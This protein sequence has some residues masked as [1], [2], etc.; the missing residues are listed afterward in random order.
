MLDY[1]PNNLS[2]LI[3]SDKAVRIIGK[4][5][6]EAE[7]FLVS[8]SSEKS[9][10]T[11]HANVVNILTSVSAMNWEKS[12]Y[13]SWDDDPKDIKVIRNLVI[14]R[15]AIINNPDV[16]RQEECKNFIVVSERFKQEVE[17]SNLKGFGF[18]E[19]DVV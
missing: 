15:L 19:I 6:T 2:W 8:I 5:K 4:V 18:W 7:V 9:K 10:N 3:F 11:K 17:R 13:V 12:D 16:F 1:V 14:N